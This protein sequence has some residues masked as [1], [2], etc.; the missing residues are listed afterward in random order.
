MIDSNRHS[1]CWRYAASQVFPSGGQLASLLVVVY[2][3]LLNSVFLL[4]GFQL[5]IWG[6]RV[7]G[8]LQEIQM[9]GMVLRS[10]RFGG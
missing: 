6:L 8:G 7:H 2:K 9:F 3:A 1:A 5:K 10:S 4:S